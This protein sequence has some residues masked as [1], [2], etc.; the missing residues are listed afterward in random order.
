MEVG[1][2]LVWWRDSHLNRTWMRDPC[3]KAQNTETNP[4]S[5][6]SHTLLFW[7][8]HNTAMVESITTGGLGILPRKTGWK[9]P[10]EVFSPATL[11]RITANSRSATAL[12]SQFLRFSKDGDSP[13]SLVSL[14]QSYPPFLEESEI[15]W[16][17][18]WAP[19]QDMAIGPCCITCNFSEG[20]TKLP[21]IMEK[22]SPSAHLSEAGSLWQ[23]LLSQEKQALPPTGFT[24]PQPSDYGSQNWV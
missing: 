18:A 6:L 11:S 13:A 15:S 22:F 23:E 1:L 7:E 2:G 19:K 20:N 8:P 24:W 10:L 12:A 14:C 5:T 3:S 4:T 21:D 16:L 17:L 9:W